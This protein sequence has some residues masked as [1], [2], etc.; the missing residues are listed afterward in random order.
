MLLITGKYSLSHI[1]EMKNEVE[2][3]VTSQSKVVKDTRKT[4]KS[5]ESEE[6][7]HTNSR[8]DSELK[9]NTNVNKGVI[10]QRK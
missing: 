1:K 3:K 5:G 8:A 7:C 10:R 9:H 6:K 4:D 2:N